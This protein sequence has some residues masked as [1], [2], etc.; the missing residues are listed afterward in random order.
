MYEEIELPISLRRPQK[1]DMLELLSLWL[2]SR[3]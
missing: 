2:I 3:L 1:D